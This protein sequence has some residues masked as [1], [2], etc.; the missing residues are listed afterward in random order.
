MNMRRFILPLFMMLIATGPAA[1]S[2]MMRNFLT[3]FRATFAR[4]AT[5]KTTF[6]QLAGFAMQQRQKFSLF[7]YS[8]LPR[9]YAESKRPTEEDYKTAFNIALG[10]IVSGSV[11]GL[12]LIL[13]DAQAGGIEP[14]DLRGSFFDGSLLHAVV[15]Y[16]SL[17][18]SMYSEYSE[19]VRM[20]V[21]EFNIPVDITDDTKQSA[22]HLFHVM[23]DERIMKELI[24]TFNELGANLELR[25]K[26]GTT[27]FRYS[28]AFVQSDSLRAAAISGLCKAGV[29]TEG[30]G[31][32]SLQEY[33]D[34]E[35]KDW[36]ENK[37]TVR[38]LERYCGC[39]SNAP[40]WDLKKRWL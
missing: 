8:L 12:R 33:H 7:A 30:T 21:K 28:T 11:D 17:N 40:W 25:D 10:A 27:P 14:K 38:A 35:E 13:R 15:R 19:I 34:R 22:A 31:A 5:A 2:A 36:P 4:N 9:V 16:A 32:R 3:P 20:L 18:K 26:Y 23:K 6:N 24:A 39:T 1:S 37:Q 29:Y